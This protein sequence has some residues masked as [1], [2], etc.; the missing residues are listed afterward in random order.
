MNM[1]LSFNFVVDKERQ[2]ITVTREFAAPLALV[3]QAYTKA[4]ILDQWWAPKP[5]KTRTKRMDFSE[6]GEWL[7][8]MVGTRRRRTLG[9]CHL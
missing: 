5:W 1:N 8:A 3:W 2:T 4:D 6:G 7:Y 9:R